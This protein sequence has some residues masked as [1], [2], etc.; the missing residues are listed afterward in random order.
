MDGYLSGWV[1]LR[2]SA[3]RSIQARLRG[4]AEV[5]RN[6]D[7]ARGMK[8]VR[9]NGP[10]RSGLNLFRLE[11]SSLQIRGD[12]AEALRVAVDERGIWVANLRPRTTWLNVE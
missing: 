2:G 1:A 7:K 4:V 6:A 12:V 11:A 9:V 5:R 3:G 8:D 10:S